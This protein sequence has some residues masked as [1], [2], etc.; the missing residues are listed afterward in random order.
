MSPMQRLLL[1]RFV[2]YVVIFYAS[3]VALVVAT[4]V[5]IRYM[6]WTP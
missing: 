3:M 5:V 1:V 4:E 6:G 2:Q